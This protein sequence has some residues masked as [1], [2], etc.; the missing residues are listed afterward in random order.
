LQNVRDNNTEV[1]YISD[2]PVIDMHM[3]S[4]ANSE[5]I[6]VTHGNEMFNY[7]QIVTVYAGSVLANVTE[8][9]A[10]NNPNVAFSTL[11]FNFETKSTIKPVIIGDNSNLILIDAGMKTLGQ[12]SFPT[13]QSRP[14]YIIPSDP[15]KNYSPVELV[16][17]LDLKTKVE[18]SF[19]MGTYQYTDNENDQIKAGTLNYIDLANINAQTQLSKLQSLPATGQKDF[20]VFDYQ[21]E[22]LARQVSYVIVFEDPEQQPRF[23]E[24]HQFSLVFINK[25]V[26]IYKVNGNLNIG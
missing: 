15:D 22:L 14:K 10:T 16:Y 18:L 11:R 24:D 23:T 21:K 12:L 7:T 5:T 3:E 26:A 13:P 25:G 1:V 17:A 8:T 6:S 9:L 2:V 20:T 19:Y 4:T